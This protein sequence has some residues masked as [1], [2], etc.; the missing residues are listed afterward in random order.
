M[1]NHSVVDL[2][3]SIKLLEEKLPKTDR[4]DEYCQLLRRSDQKGMRPLTLAVLY[5]N[6]PAFETLIKTNAYATINDYRL[7]RLVGNE[8]M[9][10]MIYQKLPE[11]FQQKL[12]QKNRQ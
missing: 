12:D 9:Q 3:Q 6:Q 2:P 1:V 11:R 5:Q 7:A 4:R 10:Q 8:T